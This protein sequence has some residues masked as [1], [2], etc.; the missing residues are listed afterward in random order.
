[1]QT[2]FSIKPKLYRHIRLDEI[3]TQDIPRHFTPSFRAFI[4]INRWRLETTCFSV[5][6]LS[7]SERASCLAGR[8]PRCAHLSSYKMLRRS[9]NKYGALVGWWQGNTEVLGDKP[10]PV[11]LSDTK[12]EW[13]CDGRTDGQEVGPPWCRGLPWPDM[14]LCQSWDAPSDTVHKHSVHTSQRTQLPL[15]RLIGW[16]CTPKSSV[17]FFISACSITPWS[18]SLSPRH[19]ASSRCG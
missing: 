17:F 16:S 12:S 2:A 6:I 4:F 11:P 8:A 7:T 10:V 1:M 15:K 5:S 18:R 13:R 19:G 14:L 9:M 3:H